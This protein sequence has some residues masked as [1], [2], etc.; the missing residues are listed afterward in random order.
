MS[1][2]IAENSK[3]ILVRCCETKGIPW[4]A[5][6]DR[7]ELGRS[8]GKADRVALTIDDVGMASAIFKALKTAGREV[9]SVGVVEW[10]K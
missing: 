4:V 1:E 3:R 5:L 9:I 7:H 8:I 10:P 2:D 6:G